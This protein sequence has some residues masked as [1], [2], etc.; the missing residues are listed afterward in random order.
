MTRYGLGV[1]NGGDFADPTRLA[2]LAREA[3]AAGWDGFFLWDHLIRR[4]PWQPMVDPW[5][6]LAAVAVATER[7]DIGPMVT[8]LPRRRVAVV[9]RQT[10]TL[11]RLSGGRLR[12]GVG[13]GAPD[14]EFTRFGESADP[15][16]RARILD[17]SLDALH[18]LWSGE[19][20]SYRGDHVV[21]DEVEFTPTPVNGRVPI[22]V[23]GGWPG[24]AP[25]RR[26]ARFDGVWPVAAAG[27]YLAVDEFVECVAAVRGLRP[28]THRS[29]PASSTAVRR[30][31][32]GDLRQAGPPGR[33]RDDLVDR[34]ARRPRRALRGPPRPR[35]SRPTPLTPTP[36]DA[37]RCVSGH[38][39]A[40]V[41]GRR[42]PAV[43]EMARQPAERDA[44][45]IFR[46]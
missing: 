22:W 3:E 17:E 42:R 29:M 21:L 8:P 4:P 20:V 9:A 5:V 2:G 6:T 39:T 38:R 46:W 32:R 24:G 41:S 35:P 26:A 28:T 13:L 1:P 45:A 40:H 36:K 30:A 27:G 25:F 18:L 14:D 16:H 15:R 37:H 10:S 11:D 34:L 43:A 7:I 19:T 33:C 44:D 23:A 12:L 31:G